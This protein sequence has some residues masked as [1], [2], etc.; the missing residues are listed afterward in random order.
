[1][2]E[3][4]LTAEY[5][6]THAEV[7]E[8]ANTTIGSFGLNS[9]SSE[10]TESFTTANS[11]TSPQSPKE[12]TMD[13]KTDPVWL[14][15]IEE[16]LTQLKAQKATMM[17]Q[18]AKILQKLGGLEATS[19]LAPIPPT[20][21]RTSDSKLKLAPPNDFDG[22]W[23]KGCA[24]LTSCDLYVNLVPHQFAD[25]EKAILWAISLICT[26]SAWGCKTPI[27]SLYFHVYIF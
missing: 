26:S 14:E 21:T 10:D 13:T 16:E 1:L 8:I 2:P 12:I 20:I 19:I 11:E 23:S 7:S 22:T 3:V 9:D 18:Q 4:A 25:D 15:I 5:S 27:C 6:H 24:F 17:T